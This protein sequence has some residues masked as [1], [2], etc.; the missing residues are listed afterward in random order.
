LTGTL[1]PSDEEEQ[2]HTHSEH[3]STS[4]HATTLVFATCRL[5]NGE[6]WNVH[7][8]NGGRIQSGQNW[9][10]RFVTRT[11]THTA[12]MEMLAGADS[13]QYSL[14][15]EIMA[16]AAYEILCRDPSVTTGNFYVDDDVLKSVGITDMSMLACQKISRT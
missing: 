4:E 1:K 13:N 11:A 9:R 2:P 15:P 16:D 7:T 8:L 14:K 12:A 3:L 10:K 6:V 5:H